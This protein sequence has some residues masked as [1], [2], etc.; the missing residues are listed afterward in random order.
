MQGLQGLQGPIGPQGPAGVGTALSRAQW[1]EDD[2]RF[3]TEG[4]RGLGVRLQ[5][6]EILSSPDVQLNS[7]GEYVVQTAGFYRVQVVVQPRQHTW[8]AD[9]RLSLYRHA[10]GVGTEFA[11]VHSVDRSNLTDPWPTTLTLD[12]VIQAAAGER[13]MIYVSGPDI[14]NFLPWPTGTAFVQIERLT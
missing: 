4:L 8:G 9:S 2:H 5:N 7:F 14:S 11:Q 12:T 3:A 6:G 10:S 1:V 13:L